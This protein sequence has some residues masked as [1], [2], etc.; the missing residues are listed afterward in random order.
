MWPAV[1]FQLHTQYKEVIPAFHPKPVWER[2][3]WFRRP[4][5]SALLPWKEGKLTFSIAGSTRL[6]R[7]V[8]PRFGPVLWTK[9]LKPSWS[10]TKSLQS[11]LTTEETRKQ[12]TSWKRGALRVEK[13]GEACRVLPGQPAAFQG[14]THKH[15]RC[16]WWLP[17]AWVPQ[18]SPRRPYVKC[19]GPC[20]CLWPGLTIGEPLTQ[21]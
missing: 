6:N 5:A 10:R 18:A 11:W 21:S 15:Y 17:A 7:V 9:H 16:V 1:S 8:F 13:V 19:S 12:K 3:A 14:A 4:G 20:V 2:K